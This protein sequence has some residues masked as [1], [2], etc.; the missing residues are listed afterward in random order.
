LGHQTGIE[1]KLFT[2]KISIKLTPPIKKLASYY[3]IDIKFPI[4]SFFH[5]MKISIFFQSSVFRSIQIDR[6]KEKKWKICWTESKM[7]NSFSWLSKI[8]H[9]KTFFLDRLNYELLNNFLRWI[10]HVTDYTHWLCRKNFLCG[11][12]W[13]FQYNGSNVRMIYKEIDRR[14][15]N[16]IVGVVHQ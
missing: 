1:A 4:K 15:F 13:K 7:E 10:I 16:F 12:R 14:Y 3:V 2:Y 9:S 6:K 11:S 8:A 5:C